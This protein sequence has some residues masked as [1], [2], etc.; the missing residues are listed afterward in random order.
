MD[1]LI[2]FTTSGSL[3]DCVDKKMVVMLRDGRKLIGVL[4]SYDQF[5]N[6]VLEDSVE[7]IH[8]GAHFAD[9]PRGVFLIRGENVVLLGEVDLD[10][11]DTVPL[12]P[13]TLQAVIP[14]HL[15][16]LEA[17]RRR[18][19]QKAKILYE[20]HGFCREGGEGDGY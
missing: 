7:R 5:A 3:V 14:I 2:P 15:E 6:L 20:Q 16:D 8:H 4:R 19:A 13:V 17:R 10:L 9:I 12:I 18:D 1:A 11:E